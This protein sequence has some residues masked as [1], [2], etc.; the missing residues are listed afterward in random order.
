MIPL[1][2]G[3]AV[4]LVLIIILWTIYNRMVQAK[5]IVEE[6]F[7]NIDIQLKKRYELIPNL[8]EAI[9]G[10]NSHEASVLEKIVLGRSGVG[11]SVAETAATDGSIT[12]TLKNFR[13]QVEAY[14]D[15]QAN[16]QFIKL[17]DAL[18]TVENELSMARRYYNGTVRDFNN[19][20][21][22]FPNVLFAGMFG[23]KKAAFYEI[24]AGEKAAPVVDL[25]EE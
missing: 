14:P 19:T 21:E 18:S 5:N 23:F 10:Y 16:T 7:S 11:N 12:S 4:V 22:V 17:M 20:L 8:I 25:S 3:G 24:E 9:K 13:I 15:L 6:G 1:I 2:V